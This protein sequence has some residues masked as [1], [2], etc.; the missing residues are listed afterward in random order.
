MELNNNAKSVGAKLI[1][2]K[3]CLA[4]KDT[5]CENGWVVK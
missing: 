4:V 1:S 5:F 3:I 2:F